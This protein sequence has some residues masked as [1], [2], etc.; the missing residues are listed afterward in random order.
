MRRLVQDNAREVIVTPRMEEFNRLFPDRSDSSSKLDQARGAAEYLGAVVVLKGADTVIA[1]PDGRIAINDNAP[2]WLATA[3][4]GD[5]LTGTIAGLA[6]QSMPAFHAACAGVW[7]H[8][9]AANNIGPGLIAS[10]LD[11][12]VKSMMEGLYQRR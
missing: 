8:G 6:A 5:V 12:G 2:A 1:D 11:Q 4:S 9:E 7:I 10:D 3:G